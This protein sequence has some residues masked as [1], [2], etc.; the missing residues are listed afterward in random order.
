MPISNYMQSYNRLRNPK[1]VRKFPLLQM[2]SSEHTE[3]TYTHLKCIC[4]FANLFTSAC[5]CALTIYGPVNLFRLLCY[6]H[7]H[8]T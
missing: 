6:T 4:A 8:T 1:E 7:I 5:L 3:K 2:E